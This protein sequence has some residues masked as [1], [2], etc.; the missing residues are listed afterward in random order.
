MSIV[1]PNGDTLVRPHLPLLLVVAD[2]LR[3][4]CELRKRQKVNPLTLYINHTAHGRDLARFMIS[5][6]SISTISRD[7]HF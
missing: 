6:T 4:L 3:F 2:G 5:T 1:T 7:N